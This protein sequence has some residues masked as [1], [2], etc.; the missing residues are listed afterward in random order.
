MLLPTVWQQFAFLVSQYF[1]HYYL[2]HTFPRWDI[3][4]RS[5]PHNG[6]KQRRVLKLILATPLSICIGWFY[7][8]LRVNCRWSNSFFN[9]TPDRAA[10][11]I[12]DPM[13]I[14]AKIKTCIIFK[15][16]LNSVRY[17]RVNQ[18]DSQISKLV[19]NNR[20]SHSSKQ[21]TSV[22]VLLSIFYRLSRESEYNKRTYLQNAHLDN[23]WNP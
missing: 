8:K 6:F 14:L 4:C 16:I 21:Y 18:I 3:E 19:W 22:H 2:Y 13:D 9:N 11:C 12:D 10:W 5:V 20:I 17:V 7:R 23:L 1:I 15:A